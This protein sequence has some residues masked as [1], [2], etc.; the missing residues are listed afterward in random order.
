MRRKV[1]KIPAH[2]GSTEWCKEMFGKQ[3]NG[4]NW[5]YHRSHMYFTDEQMYTLYMLKWK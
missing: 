2:E 4:G 1:W 3:V 5:W